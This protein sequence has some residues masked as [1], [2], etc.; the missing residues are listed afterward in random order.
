MKRVGTLDTSPGNS[1]Q[2]SLQRNLP[3]PFNLPKDLFL[4]RI[5]TSPRAETFHPILSEAQDQFTL[6]METWGKAGLDHLSQWIEIVICNPAVETK[7]LRIDREEPRR[8]VPQ[9]LATSLR[10]LLEGNRRSRVQNP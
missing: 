10:I 6:Q 9:P 2:Y 4:N 3:T 5:S 7:H 1:L 8:E